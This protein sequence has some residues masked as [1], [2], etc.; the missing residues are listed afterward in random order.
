[1]RRSFAACWLARPREA[2][3]ALGVVQGLLRVNALNYALKV[4]ASKLRSDRAARSSRVAR[5]RSFE[6]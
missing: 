2:G 3:M 4:E 6:D 5:L 1:M